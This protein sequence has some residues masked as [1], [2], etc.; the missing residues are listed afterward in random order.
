MIQGGCNAV[1]PTARQTCQGCRGLRAKGN[2]K[3]MKTT[4]KNMMTDQEFEDTTEI[5]G[6]KDDI[7]EREAE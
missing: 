2:V 1:C 6:L 3:A 4:L 7:E 5:Y